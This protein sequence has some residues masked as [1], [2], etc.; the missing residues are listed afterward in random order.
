M[1]KEVNVNET[2]IHMCHVCGLP[3]VY[4]LPR[5]LKGVFAHMRC[6]FKT[7]SILDAEVLD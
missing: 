2:R 1:P 6:V 5:R 3:I 7:P 4:R